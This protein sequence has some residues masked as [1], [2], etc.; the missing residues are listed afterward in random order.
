MSSRVRAGLLAAAAAAAGAAGAAGTRRLAAGLPQRASQQWERTNYAGRP[1]TLLEGPAWVAGAATG[2]GVAAMLDRDE[3]SAAAVPSSPAAAL[4]VT[5]ASGALG[6]FDDLSG[7]A[8]RKGLKGHLGALRRGELT[9]GA[10]KIAGLAVTGLAGAVLTDRAGDRTRVTGGRGGG[11]TG[12]AIVE[13]L[14]GG[15]VVAATAN[16]VNLF[17]LRPGRALKVVMAGTAP[18]GMAGSTSAAS[19]LGASAGVIRDDLAGVSML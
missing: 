6:A 1:L 10:V 19:A 13:T 8:S 16:V 18:L 4:L 2:I 15:A 12:R 17:D 14:V 11:R 7:S 9:T 5:V 3:T